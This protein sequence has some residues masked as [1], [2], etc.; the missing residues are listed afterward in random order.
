MRT[1]NGDGAHRVR[2]IASRCTA[3]RA[4]GTPPLHRAGCA[5]HDDLIGG[6]DG[7]CQGETCRVADLVKREREP[8]RTWSRGR[9]AAHA[10]VR[11]GTSSAAHRV[12]VR[13]GCGAEHRGAHQSGVHRHPVRTRVAATRWIPS[14]GAHSVH[15]IR[16][17]ASRIG[18]R[19]SWV[20]LRT[21]P[22][23]TGADVPPAA[24]GQPRRHGTPRDTARPTPLR[25][26]PAATA[27][28][29]RHT[30]APPGPA[31]AR[32]GT[33]VDRH[34]GRTTHALLGERLHQLLPR[35]PSTLGPLRGGGNLLLRLA[36]HLPPR[37]QLLPRPHLTL[38]EQTDH[39]RHLTLRGRQ[40][41]CAA[42]PYT[43]AA[44]P[45]T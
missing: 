15:S 27:A 39:R 36:Q 26:V 29:A 34:G 7:L 17:R 37:L 6:R 41:P 12:V 14:G 10:P 1:G 8:G 31:P 32:L 18:C 3:L 20:P 19:T 21:A 40:Q 11:C 25:P 35:H 45:R 38:L 2:T 5:S 22:A 4:S 42:C 23:A 28:D 30:P 24:P 43:S 9:S 44:M 33:C 16:C 13:T